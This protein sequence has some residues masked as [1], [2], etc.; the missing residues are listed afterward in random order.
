MKK[1]QTE[2]IEIPQLKI[3][4]LILNIKGDTALIVHKWAAKAKK[5]IQDKGEGKPIQ[6]RVKR[7][8]ENEYK[9]C[10]YNHPDGGYGFPAIAFKNAAVRAAKD[11]GINMTDARR[12]FHINNEFVKIEGTPSMREDMVRVA[13]GGADIRYRPEF[14]E[15]ST[16]LI[17]E[18]NS[19]VISA[20]QITNLFYL[21]GFGVGV[22]D[23]RPEKNGNFGKFSIV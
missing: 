19:T 4:T 15:W 9:D 2:I 23:W 6:G 16:E 20:E 8:P 13:T 11:A 21:A 12:M 1:S 14:K 5:A 7:N 17:I 22:G 18:F 10:F 3:G